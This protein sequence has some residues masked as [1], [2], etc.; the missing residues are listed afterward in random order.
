MQKVRFNYKS[1]RA[2]IEL[3]NYSAVLRSRATGVKMQI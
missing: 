2:I 3:V 1:E